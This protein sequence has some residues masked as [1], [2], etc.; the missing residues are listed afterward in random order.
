MYSKGKWLIHLKNKYGYKNIF[1]RNIYTSRWGPYDH[2]DSYKIEALRGNHDT[3]FDIQKIEIHLCERKVTPKLRFGINH[4]MC[5]MYKNG[6]YQM[7]SKDESL[8]IPRNEW[9]DEL[10]YLLFFLAIQ[11]LSTR[12][13]HYKRYKNKDRGHYKAIIKSLFMLRSIVEEAKRRDIYY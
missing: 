11:E 7:I 5:W 4:P 1:Q 10:C 8:F 13:Y 12:V 9:S 2:H 3:T 6:E